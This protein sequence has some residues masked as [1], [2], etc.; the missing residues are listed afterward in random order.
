MGNERI[1]FNNESTR[2]LLDWG[3]GVLIY[4]N[5]RYWEAG[6]GKFI[7]KE[8]GFNIGY[9]FRDT[10]ND[11]ENILLVNGKG[12]KLEQVEFNIPVKDGSNDTRFEMDFVPVFDRNSYT[13][14]ELIS[15]AQH[16]VF[17]WYLMMRRW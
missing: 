2:G 12:H 13:S 5:K 9:G 6:T 15:S 14:V 1:D 8:I 17:G 7:D 4:H 16:Q 10:S 3:K 11:S